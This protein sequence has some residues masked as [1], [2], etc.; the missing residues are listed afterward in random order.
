MTFV[1]SKPKFTIKANP[2]AILRIA[3]SKLPKLQKILYQNLKSLK[4]SVSVS[5]L[6]KAI[7]NDDLSGAENLIGSIDIKSIE[8]IFKEIFEASGN[9]AM[10]SIIRKQAVGISFD[11]LN[12]RAIAFIKK[13]TAELVTNVS[14]ENKQAIRAI[15]QRAF[16]E[17]GH[18]MIQ[19]KRIINYIGLTEKQANAVENFYQRQINQGVKQSIAE[20]Q[21]EKYADRLL[22]YR[23]QTIAQTET[24]RA[25]N[26][27]ER[28]GWRQEV[29]AGVINENEWE[30]ESVA[31][32]DEYTCEFC[33]DMDGKRA[34][35]NGTYP[36]GVEGPPYHPNCRCTEILVEREK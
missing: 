22:Q 19:A 25:S 15:I 13:H 23:A 29:D 1:T 18:P 35:I 12:P 30:R 21:T 32:D 20:S 36:G 27:G 4:D 16:E 28:E 31:T 24:M 34:P 8:D 26:E 10:K 2:N 17:G 14:D 5:D 6:A 3:D 11:L 7:E 9:V 33:L